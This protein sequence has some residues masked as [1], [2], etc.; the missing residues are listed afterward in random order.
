MGISY[1]NETKDDLSYATGSGDSWNTTMVTGS[2]GQAGRYTS[3]VYDYKKIPHITYFDVSTGN[4]YEATYTSTKKVKW[5]FRSIDLSYNTGIASVLNIDSSN[6]P[7]IL[8]Y[9]E[10]LRAVELAQRTPPWVA[11]TVTTTNLSTNKNLGFRIDPNTGRFHAALYD[12]TDQDLIYATKGGL[13]WQYTTVDSTGNVGQNPSL[14]LDASGNPYISYY[15]ATNGNLKLAYYNGSTW[16]TEV[17][18]ATPNNTGLY[19]SIGI[20]QTTGQIYI[21][22]FDSTAARMWIAYSSATTPH[23]FTLTSVDLTADTGR[24]LA[25]DVRPNDGF[26]GIAY[27]DASNQDLKYAIATAA[28]PPWTFTLTTVDATGAVGKYCSMVFDSWSLPHVSY[29]DETNGNLKYAYYDGSTW[30][31]QTVDSN[32]NVGLW[33]SIATEPG[34]NIPH[35]SYYDQTKGKMKYTYDPPKPITSIV[36]LPFIFR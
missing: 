9:N 31:P 18:D 24:F 6:R 35:I 36:Y 13:F 4:M 16:T 27:Y 33:T 30:T 5:I 21:A 34:T 8:Y 26:P 20:N 2:L 32:G 11:E 17:V 7:Y 10:S 15:D 3:L 28:A 22:Y 23:V 19:S 29:Y 25:L 12:S 1:F 14:D